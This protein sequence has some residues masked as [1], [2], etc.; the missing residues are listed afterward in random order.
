MGITE[1]AASLGDN[2]YFG[3]GFGLFGIGALAAGG[4]RLTQVR[5]ANKTI[6][7]LV[8]LLICSI[9]VGSLHYVSSPLH[10]DCGSDL[11]LSLIHI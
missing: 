8:P 1:L 4:K 3:A 9:F 7:L 10:D 5:N 2:P 6:R 11:Q